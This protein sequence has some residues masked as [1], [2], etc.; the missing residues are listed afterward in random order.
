MELSVERVCNSLARSRILP[1]DEV[2]KLHQRWTTTEAPAQARDTAAF[3]RWLVDRGSVTE[4]QASVLARGHGDALAL[5]YYTLQDRI[6]RGRMAGVYRAAHQFG[7]TVA[8]KI[9]P[10]S[11]TKDP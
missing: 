8:I 11:K 5:S 2:R 9:L 3:I 4:F 1:A 6:G 7:Q 10:P